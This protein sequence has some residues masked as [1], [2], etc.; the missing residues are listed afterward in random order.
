MSTSPITRRPDWAAQLHAL[1]AARARAPFAWGSQDCCLFVCDAIAAMTG[2][3]P[4][5]DVRGSY[6]TERGAARLV[7]RLGGMAA[8]GASRFGAAVPV[9]AAQ[10]GD[11]GLIEHDGRLSLAL[12]GGDHWLAAGEQGLERLPLHEA[13]QAWRCC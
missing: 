3:D 6:R 1:L 4:A 5:W 11:V 8:I 12:C 10:V 13:T 7:K 2:H 9:L